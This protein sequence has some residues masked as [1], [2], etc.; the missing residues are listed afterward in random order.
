VGARGQRFGA[1]KRLVSRKR[2]LMLV[3]YITLGAHAGAGLIRRE[4]VRIDARTL[5]TMSPDLAWNSSV[6]LRIALDGRDDATPLYLLHPRVAPLAAIASR[7]RRHFRR[8]L[9]PQEMDE[10]PRPY[11][12]SLA[13]SQYFSPLGSEA[14]A[15]ADEENDDDEPALWFQLHGAVVR[16]DIPL[17]AALDAL[18]RPTPLPI[19]LTLH[20]GRPPSNIAALDASDDGFRAFVHSLKQ[21]AHLERGTARSV[22]T[23]ALARQRALYAA[24]SAGDLSSYEDLEDVDPKRVPC[25]VFVDGC[26]TWTQLPFAAC[27]EHGAPATV[28]EAL[29]PCV[30]RAL[31]INDVRRATAVCHGVELPWDCV[32]VDAWRALRC[33]DHFLYVAVRLL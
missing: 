26:S 20:I 13:D 5:P 1:Q 2:I 22:L 3:P 15:E 33:G 8:H 19:D 29:G 21:A 27:N 9:E 16:W 23:L 12:P 18:G 28:G 24:C 10:S 6:P 17:G 30:R 11:A 7:L 14:W 25:R 32:L 31:S 4:F